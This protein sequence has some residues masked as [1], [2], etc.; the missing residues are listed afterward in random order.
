MKKS[1]IFICLWSGWVISALP[2]VKPPETKISNGLIDARLYLPDPDNGYYRGSRF[3]WSGVI[4]S[5]DH[6][7][8]HYFGQWFTEYSPTL[9]DAI[10]GPVEAFD[11]IGYNEAKK[12]D[13]FL[14][15]GIGV[16]S[17]TG[18]SP[19]AFTEAYPILNAGKWKVTTHPDQVQFRHTLQ[20]KVYSYE[21]DKT[22]KLVKNK[23]E[24]VLTHTLKNTGQRTIETS[25]Y[26]HNFFV[27]DGQTTGPGFT[28]TF[29]FAFPEGGSNDMKEFVQFKDH[30][31]LFLKDLNPK[32]HVLFRDLT[33]GKTADYEIKIENHK[34]GAAVKITGD[35]PISKFVFWCASTTLCPEP[36]IKLKVDPGKEISWNIRYEFY[37]CNIVK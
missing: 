36:F 26:N 1:S 2:F 6:N 22:V 30:Q 28:V 11:P 4:A 5:L 9:H 31:L 35:Q 19:Y 34:T 37:E 15:V 25:V 7:G 23:P 32:E 8:H 3:D 29:P 24:M 33:A 12:G 14:K 20:D 10:L 17:K 13:P 21:Y 18:E 27:M 16:L